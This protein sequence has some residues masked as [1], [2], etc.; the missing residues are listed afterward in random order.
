MEFLVVKVLGS[1]LGE[2]EEAEWA[3]EKRAQGWTGTE[4]EESP[5][6]DLYSVPPVVSMVMMREKCDL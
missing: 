1:F 4:I 2:R 5:G 6:Y 3:V